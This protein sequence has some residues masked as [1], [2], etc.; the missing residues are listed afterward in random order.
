MTFLGPDGK[1]RVAVY[2]GLPRRFVG[3]SSGAGGFQGEPGY[4]SRFQAS[5]SYSA[6]RDL[7]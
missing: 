7:G 3:T 4:R 2:T 1:Q 5:L 6:E